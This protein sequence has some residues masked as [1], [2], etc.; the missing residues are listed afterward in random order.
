MHWAVEKDARVTI[1]TDDD[2]K[3]L[4]RAADLRIA[5]ITTTG[6][7]RNRRKLRQRSPASIF[8]QSFELSASGQKG[9]DDE[10]VKL[11]SQTHAQY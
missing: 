1:W 8:P 9:L 3:W 11:R 6:I 5:A 2:P 4:K 10:M 7:L